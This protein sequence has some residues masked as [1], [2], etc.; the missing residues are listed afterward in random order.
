[1]SGHS[2]PEESTKQID[3][4]RGWNEPVKDDCKAADECVPNTLRV[5]RFAERE[6]V[7][8]FRCA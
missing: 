6:E 7:F 1:M 4:F 2:R 8:E 5:Q 3:V